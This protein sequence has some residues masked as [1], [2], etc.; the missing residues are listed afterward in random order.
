MKQ[1]GTVLLTDKIEKAPIPEHMYNK[2]IYINPLNVP[3]K[4]VESKRVSKQEFQKLPSN[5]MKVGELLG[6]NEMSIQMSEREK[7]PITAIPQAPPSD[8]RIS[9][10]DFLKL[11]ENKQFVEQHIDYYKK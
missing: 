1:S 7:T 2:G 9:K 11:G 6:V 8:I 3:V 10:R 5:K 4:H